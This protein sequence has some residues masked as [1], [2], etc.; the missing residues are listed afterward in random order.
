VLYLYLRSPQPMRI[1]AVNDAVVGVAIKPQTWGVVDYSAPPPKGVKLQLSATPHAQIDA[2]VI[3]Q[4]DGWPA[5]AQPPPR[6]PQLMAWRNSD[7]TLV[8]A[9]ASLAG[10]P[11]AAPKSAPVHAKGDPGASR[12]TGSDKV[13]RPAPNA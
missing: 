4:R 13:A 1:E 8:M 10:R 5:D 12:R 2:V 9:R 11:P 6:P 7:T 3:E